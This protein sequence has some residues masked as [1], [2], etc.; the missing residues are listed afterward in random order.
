[1][2][3]IT[4]SKKGLPLPRYSLSNLNMLFFK[5]GGFSKNIFSFHCLG[6]SPKSKIYPSRAT[7]GSDLAKKCQSDKNENKNVVGDFRRI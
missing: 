6:F 2:P 3:F 7:T 4:R 1:M 5:G